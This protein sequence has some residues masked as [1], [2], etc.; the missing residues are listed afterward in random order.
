[1]TNILAVMAYNEAY[2]Q[3]RFD[4]AAA[5]ANIILVMTSLIGFFYVRNQV[6]ERS[7]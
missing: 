6:K 1:M 3:Y 4:L 7:L 2:N 5:M